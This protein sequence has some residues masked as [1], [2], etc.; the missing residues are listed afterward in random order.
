MSETMFISTKDLAQRWSMSPTGAVN[1]AKRAGIVIVRLGGPSGTTVRFCLAEI[2]VHE[3]ACMECMVITS[4]R[5]SHSKRLP[6]H[7]N[8]EV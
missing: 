6:F 7:E 4:V 3:R 5:S 1:A 2:E 8:A